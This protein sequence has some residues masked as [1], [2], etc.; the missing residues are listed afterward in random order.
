MAT[1]LQTQ[2]WARHSPKVIQ[3]HSSSWE[4]SEWPSWEED[5]CGNWLIFWLPDCSCVVA[6][7]D[8]IWQRKALTACPW[9]GD[10]LIWDFPTTQAVCGGFGIQA[11]LTIWKAALSP[12]VLTESIGTAFF[13]KNISTKCSAAVQALWVVAAFT[14]ERCPVKQTF[15]KC[16]GSLCKAI[17]S[18]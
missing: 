14:S 17:K 2:S 16:P 13:K 18:R 5:V 7:R 6:L 9:I 4:L 1:S 10:M 12:C 3:L 11:S 15:C 8:K